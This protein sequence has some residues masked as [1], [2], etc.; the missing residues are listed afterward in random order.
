MRNK[1]IIIELTSLLDVILIMLFWLMMNLQEQNKNISAEA[2]QRIAQ[3]EEIVADAEKISA[4]SLSE[5]E[6]IKTEMQELRE[7]TDKEITEA[8]KKS[9]SINDTATA[10]LKA[11]ENFEQGSFILIDLCYNSSGEVIIS[12][13]SETIGQT[14]ILSD[15]SISQEI[16]NSF[17][18]YGFSKDN[19]IICAVTYN[20][21]HALYKDVRA[22]RMAVDDVKKSYPNFYCTYINNKER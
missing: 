16:I 14:D 22:V 17:K 21:S 9:A 4:D 20:G 3:A 15:A 12:D 1:G 13:T 5:L 10:N 8:W 7:S 19:T 6:K 18:D 11:L 2:E